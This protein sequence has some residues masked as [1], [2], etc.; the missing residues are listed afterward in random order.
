MVSIVIVS[1]HPGLAAG[2]K[3]LASQMVQGN[4]PIAV[5]AGIDDPDDPIGTDATRILEAIL[6]VY[7]DDGVVVFMDLGS[8]L[9][10]TDMALEFLDEEQREHVFL[11]DAPIVEGVMSAVTQAASGGDVQSVLNEAKGALQQKQSQLA[12]ELGEP[13]AQEEKL[14]EAE[15]SESAITLE[16]TIINPMGLHARPAANFVQAVNRFK[17]SILVQN[18]SRGKFRVNA[19]SIN[20]VM[21]QE[22]RKGDSIT[23]W[24]DGEDARTA[25]EALQQLAD[26][27]FG[28]EEAVKTSVPEKSQSVIVKQLDDGSWKGSR[29]GTGLVVDK[30]THFKTIDFL[31]ADVSSARDEPADVAWERFLLA[32]NE[33]KAELE[34]QY[35]KLKNL[36]PSEA[37]IF[38]AHILVLSD[39]ELQEQVKKK[40]NEEKSIESAWQKSILAMEKNY[41]AMQDELLKSRAHDVHD[42]GNQVMGKLL[43]HKK[44]EVGQDEKIGIIMAEELQPSDIDKLNPEYVKGVVIAKGN[45][46]SHASIL[47]RSTGIP[48][49]VGVGMQAIEEVQDGEMVILDA[50]HERFYA[51]PEPDQLAKF[52]KE[53]K[54]WEEKK[55]KAQKAR[56]QPAKTSDGTELKVLA[57]IQ[58]SKDMEKA[59][60]EGAEGVGLFRT[61]YLFLNRKNAPGFDEQYQE[62]CA[63]LKALPKDYPLT[64]RTM[65]IGG[66]KQVAYLNQGSEDNPFLGWRG[67]RYHLD[68]PDLL[69]VQLKAIAKA[70]V[71]MEHP[72]KVMFPMVTSAS[73]IENAQAVLG[74]I[75]H[76]MEEASS[77]MDI[78]IM[79]EVPAAAVLADRLL[80]HVDFVSIGTNDLTQYTLAA[81][82]TN[83]N[84]L[85]MVNPFHPAV[86]SLIQNV[87]SS[88]NKAGKEVSMCGEMAGNTEALP[89]LY[90]L[91]LR[92]FSMSASQIPF[93][94][95]AVRSLDVHYAKKMAEK[96]LQCSVPEEVEALLKS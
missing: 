88:A 27:G 50:G 4:V 6:E 39:D 26:E 37:D 80:Q 90:G 93:F 42:V 86:L 10:S 84:V 79:I 95:E 40:L 41:E 28:E 17:S 91:G 44:N 46:T 52:R 32:V 87:I 76:E 15:I 9:L 30:A 77:L 62:Y 13:E 38:Q 55:E 43:G 21:L 59:L 5:G 65:D 75:F 54:E 69:S 33:A 22:I 57:N 20:N 45:T 48:A 83:T 36:H 11:S 61:E 25:K 29:L 1:H 70:A 8:A 85:N 63:A 72:V 2:I 64:I 68:R 78:G 24:F 74:N 58:G 34:Q 16:L 47:L 53:L 94:K 56:K 19:K 82:R 18:K 23:L 66:D 71:D 14:P 35:N 89:V 92:Q 31:K 96:A 60:D 51:K 12:E 81:D 3:A 7:T 49:L 73:E 67:L